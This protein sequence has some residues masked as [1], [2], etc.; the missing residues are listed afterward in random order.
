MVRGLSAGASRI[1]TLGPTTQSTPRGCEGPYYPERIKLSHRVGPV[2]LDFSQNPALLTSCQYASRMTASGSPGT[3]AGMPR[4]TGGGRG[5]HLT[6]PQR[7][8]RPVPSLAPSAQRAKAIPPST[9]GP[10]EVSLCAP[11]SVQGGKDAEKRRAD[12][13][14]P[15]RKPA[16]AAR[17]PRIDQREG[18]R[19]TF[20][21]FALW[22]TGQERCPTAIATSTVSLSE[23]RDPGRA[24]GTLSWP[25]KGCRG[26]VNA[27]RL[28]GF[29]AR[30]NV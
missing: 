29:G 17:S 14:Y 13:D 3:P 23:M 25:P 30:H 15:C 4:H 7:C 21:P 27:G 24:D 2:H 9:P 11:R 18:G 26:N 1:R 8:L 20:R 10:T 22:R 5:P 28:T 19:P 12:L 16:A 6:R